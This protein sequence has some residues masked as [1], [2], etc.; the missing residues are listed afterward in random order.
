MRSFWVRTTMVVFLMGQLLYG[1]SLSKAD[2]GFPFPV[3]PSGIN[4]FGGKI[5][6]L[7][8]HFDTSQTD[9]L[10][11]DETL[12][13]KRIV[14]GNGQIYYED[15]F[16]SVVEYTTSP[17]K[18]RTYSPRIISM[19]NKRG[20]ESLILLKEDVLFFPNVRVFGVWS[21][22]KTHM[23]F[24]DATTAERIGGL[25][26]AWKDV[27]QEQLRINLVAKEVAIVSDGGR[28]RDVVDI[29]AG[30]SLIEHMAIDM[31]K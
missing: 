21:L 10:V 12:S 8:T 28:R 18:G 6:T 19:R 30:K 20:Q 14:T 29:K 24:Y 25:D 9:L 27:D 11:L 7:P 15:G 16:G 3:L 13:P 23:V 22:D 2:V 17:D 4:V 1:G 5:V 26:V 31:I